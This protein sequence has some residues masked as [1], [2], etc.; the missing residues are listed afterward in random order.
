M[1]FNSEE[2]KFLGDGTRFEMTPLAN[3]KYQRYN[4]ASL[5]VFKHVG[6]DEIIVVGAYYEN[7]LIC[8]CESLIQ[9]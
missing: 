7:S 2:K 4:N 3:L 8:M 5:V 6:S 1:F 9:N